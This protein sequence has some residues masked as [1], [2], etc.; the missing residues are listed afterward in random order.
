VEFSS[1]NVIYLF[2]T[3]LSTL[4]MR[5]TAHQYNCI[6]EKGQPLTGVVG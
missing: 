1:N 6:N 5:T 4:Q 3:A 2:S